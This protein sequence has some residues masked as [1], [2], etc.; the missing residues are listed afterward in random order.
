M[1]RMHVY[2]HSTFSRHNLHCF[3]Q[4]H[5]RAKT[6]AAAVTRQAK[7]A[8]LLDDS[9][10]LSKIRGS[11]ALQNLF[12]SSRDLVRITADLRSIINFFGCWRGSNIKRFVP[13][14]TW[15]VKK[16]HN[17]TLFLWAG[18]P[19]AG[20]S[21]PRQVASTTARTHRFGQQALQHYLVN[22][23]PQFREEFG[24]NGQLR[25]PNRRRATLVGCCFQA[26]LKQPRT[27]IEDTSDMF[28]NLRPKEEPA[29]LLIRGLCAQLRHQLRSFGDACA[30][31][32]H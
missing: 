13:T 17:L 27:R 6:F 28:L 23:L 31:L 21:H 9:P 16:W 20:C 10:L 32:F 3:L 15:T 8:G 30:E 24:T 4:R 29:K 22:A 2:R 14:F 18:G 5:R 7:A 19:E 25:T 1:G 26:L 11:C 12:G